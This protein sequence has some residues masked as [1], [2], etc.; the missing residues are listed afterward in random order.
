MMEI[1]VEK[2]GTKVKVVRFGRLIRQKVGIVLENK[3]YAIIS[4]ILT[5]I[6][7]KSS[8][9]SSL[10][11]R[12]PGNHHSRGQI[13]IPIEKNVLWHIFFYAATSL[14]TIGRIHFSRVVR[15]AAG[16]SR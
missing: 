12:F 3:K 5:L 6:N 2:N 10:S 7:V 16:S 13:E 1:E 8:Q 14:F 15:L 11:A 9:R 4:N